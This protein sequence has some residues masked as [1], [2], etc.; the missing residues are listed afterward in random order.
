MI[1][2]CAILFRLDGGQCRCDGPEAQ[3]PFFFI[4][5]GK[6]SAEG[7]RGVVLRK[8]SDLFTFVKVEGVIPDTSRT[9]RD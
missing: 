4:S 2:G 3:V 5:T 8:T 6:Y 7:V 1:L 9:H